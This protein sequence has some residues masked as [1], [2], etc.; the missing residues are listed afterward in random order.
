VLGMFGARRSVGGGGNLLKVGADCCLD[1]D[2]PEE[3]QFYT[4]NQRGEEILD[5][6]LRIIET[7]RL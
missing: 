4:A 6:S 5:L 7:S 1:C 2:M 3:R